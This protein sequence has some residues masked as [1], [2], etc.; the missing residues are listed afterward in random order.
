MNKDRS[1]FKVFLLR[2]Q[3]DIGEKNIDKLFKAEFGVV[4]RAKRDTGRSYAFVEFEKEEDAKKAVTAG[5]IEIQDQTEKA[6]ND[7]EGAA[8]KL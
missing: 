3:A 6:L 7:E 2:V 5:K 1:S 4:Y 8:K